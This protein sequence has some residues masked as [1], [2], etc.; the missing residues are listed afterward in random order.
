M[1]ARTKLFARSRRTTPAVIPETQIQ[2]SVTEQHVDLVPLIVGEARVSI[3]P[4]LGNKEGRLQ[5]HSL[6][7]V[8]HCKKLLQCVDFASASSLSLSAALW[9]A[10][11]MSQQKARWLTSVSVEGSDAHSTKEPVTDTVSAFGAGVATA[12]AY[13]SRH[14]LVTGNSAS[15]VA[16]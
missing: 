12:L 9:L 2:F 16:T 6:F 11:L 8:S 14:A 7:T 15:E 4:V 13:S 1:N 5:S 3:T 10:W